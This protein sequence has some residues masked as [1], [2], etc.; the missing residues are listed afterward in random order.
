MSSN[1][2]FFSR[3]INAQ[4]S[5]KKL[6]DTII[7]CLTVLFIALF[8]IG[9]LLDFSRYFLV[10]ITGVVL[11][12]LAIRQG[13]VFNLKFSYYHIGVAL[14]ILFSFVSSIWA[15][16]S[17]N[18]VSSAITIL[19]IFICCCVFYV[20]YTEKGSEMFFKAIMWAGV[21]VAFYVIAF[22]GLSGLEK[23]VNNSEQMDKDEIDNANSIGFACSVSVI[24]SIYYYVEKREKLSL[25]A[26]IPCIV[27]L[28]ITTSRTALFETVLG[29]LF[30]F[31]IKFITEKRLASLAR[32]FIILAI[33]VSLA[34]VIYNSK[35]FS[36]LGERID[37]LFKELS[38]GSGVDHS[39]HIR[40]Q[41][42]KA[43]WR[44]F[45]NNPIGGVGMGNASFVVLSDLGV[46]WGYLH[47]NYIEMLANGG[48]IGF[49]IYY[50][51]YAVL[52]VNLLKRKAFRFS[53]GRL[54]LVILITQLFVDYGTVSYY[55]KSTYV[56]LAALY[57]ALGEIRGIKND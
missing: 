12:L 33:I 28:A 27:V 51:I 53:A 56:I 24:I 31:V 19:E 55:S 32:L 2:G 25:L 14:F 49:A 6:I 9:S 35:L 40:S 11:V 50:S 44:M 20:Y 47:N 21:I 5:G 46:V 1:N 37:K 34:V 29:V 8:N 43:G 23:L 16:N 52:F 4:M 17:S 15:R 36:L 42:I 22:Y 54:A 18:A 3:I 10:L 48:I 13:F 57:I 30:I 7:W 38:T 26:S 41:M 45:L 39:A